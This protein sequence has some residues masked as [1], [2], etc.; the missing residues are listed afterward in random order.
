MANVSLGFQLS[1]S[2][3]GMSQG[4]N[5]GVVELQKLGYAAKK[6]AS[7]V[8]TLKTIEISRAFISGITTIARTFQS[9][10][11][12]AANAIDS[13]SK[14]ADSLGV[15]YGELRALQIAADLAGTSSET[16]ATA[17]TRAQVTISKAAG[18]S[19]EAK[20]ALA[21]LGLSV[22]D[23]AKKG[24]TEQF[25]AIAQA[26][27]GIENPA[28]RAAAAVAVFGKAGAQLLPAF[29]E[30]PENLKIANSFLEGFQGGINGIDPTAIVEVNDAF[31]LVGESFKEIAGRLLTELAPVLKQGASE[32]VA[33]AKSL[34]VKEAARA[35]Q[36]S[37]S[38]VAQV[39]SLVFRAAAPLASNLFPAIGAY[40]AFINRQAIALAAAQMARALAAAATAALAYSSAAKQA[41]AATAVLATAFKGFLISTGV[42]ALVVLLGAAAGAAVDWATAADSAGA[43][44]VAAVNP[45]AAAAKR[46]A[47]AFAQAAANAA[48]FGAEAEKALKVPQL[49]ATDFVESALSGAT[50]AV[51]QLAENL[52]GL[53]RVPSNIQAAFKELQ[54][55]VRTANDT[56]F[57]SANALES[58]SQNARSLIATVKALTTAEE[59]RAR[60]SKEASE[61]AARAAQDAQNRTRELAT[62]GLSASEQ[63]RLKLQEDLLAVSREIANAEKARSEAIRAGDAAAIKAANDRLRL[64]QLAGEEA[65]K[66]DRIRKL[67][68]RGID[69]NIIKPTRTLADDFKSIKDAFN[70]REL[71]GDEARLALRNLAAEGIQIRGEILRELSK[72]SQRAL[73]ISDVRTSEGISQFFAAG[74][75]DPAIEQRREQLKKLDEIRRAIIDA[76]L[77]PV[78]I[79]G[80]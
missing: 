32:F 73:Q 6:T 45:T 56:T 59:D 43:Q 2:A 18:G 41:A 29:R 30:L 74:R 44:V 60:A 25:S 70:A 78:D 68:A 1:A 8:S 12:G 19:N 9:F 55:S 13:T 26:I 36:A 10:T 54:Q 63:N 64:A 61:A 40:L 58:V 31:T 21:S 53:E 71:N 16:L 52:G 27:N 77:R 39:L 69:T 5:A 23:L 3:V 28:Q 51:K 48:E 14:L 50:S 4:I 7:D 11:S 72:P 35:V 47:D 75:Q 65:R 80:A 79:L 42:G 66:Q 62:Q 17:F 15:S 76:G 20:A 34:D 22:D 33:F 46:S 37:L 57:A 67:E 24:S 38:D 49:T